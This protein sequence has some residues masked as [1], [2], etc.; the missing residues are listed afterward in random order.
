MIEHVGSFSWKWLRSSQ[1][2]TCDDDEITYQDQDQITK[3][4]AVTMT[5]SFKIETIFVT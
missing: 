4:R 1:G 3:T 5:T 2:H